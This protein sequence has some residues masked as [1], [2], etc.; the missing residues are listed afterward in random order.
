M[1]KMDSIKVASA[2]VANYGLSLTNA[3]L[4]LQC[5]VALLTIVYLILKINKIRK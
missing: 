2:S 4:T 1:E 3:S 5:V